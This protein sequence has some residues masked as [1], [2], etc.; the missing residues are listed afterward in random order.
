MDVL[1][2]RSVAATACLLIFVGAVRPAPA[3]ERS[4]RA[5]GAL[6]V[7]AE[8]ARAAG[9]HFGVEFP[10]APGEPSFLDELADF[11]IDALVPDATLGWEDV[12]SWADAAPAPSP[13]RGRLRFRVERPVA[14]F[15]TYFTRGRGRGTMETGLRRSGRYRRMAE[16]I[17]AEE[18][19]PTDLI[20]LAQVES[21][22]RPW[23]LSRASAK[24]IWQ[25][26]PSTGRRFGLGRTHWVD[27]R[28]DPLASTRAAARY[29][30]FLH[31]HFKGDWMLALAAYNA[32]EGRVGRA[33]ARAGRADFWL[34]HRRGLLPR[35]TRNYVPAILAVITVA[36]NPARYGFRVAPARP[37]GFDRVEVGSQVD[38]RVAADCCGISL[39]DIWAHNPDLRRGVTPPGRYQLRIPEGA[40]VRFLRAYNRLPASARV[41]RGSPVD[42]AYGKS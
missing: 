29:L 9:E 23:A 6:E 16:R 28:A 40:R 37:W 34:L 25:F 27:E 41:R 11:D 30:R 36:R 10:E 5:E 19:V 1:R 20:W 14:Q 4:R 2:S 33:V 38:L 7:A 31:R 13:A 35:E 18:N 32:G 39:A 22:W 21:V 3:Q 26:I 24:G 15:V 17:F 42:E 12:P 8:I